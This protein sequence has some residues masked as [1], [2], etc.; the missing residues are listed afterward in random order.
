MVAAGGS[1]TLGPVGFHIFF[2]RPTPKVNL[3]PP[4]PKEAWASFE[5][6]GKGYARAV[7]QLCWELVLSSLR[8][9]CR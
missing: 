8:L 7:I 4:I 5:M 1:D 3:E 2:Y 6:P 9:G